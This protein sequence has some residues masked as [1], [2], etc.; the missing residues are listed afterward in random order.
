MKIQ[1]HE[2]HIFDYENL[3]QN[4]YDIKDIA[5]S[6][7]RICRFNGHVNQLSFYSVAEHC[8]WCSEIA[9]EGLRLACLLHDAAECYIGDVMKPYKLFLSDKFGQPYDLIEQYIQIYIYESFGL[10]LSFMD[11]TKISTID[12]VM[13]STEYGQCM[14]IRPNFDWDITFPPT[15]ISLIGFNPEQM[16]TLFLNKFNY[17]YNKNIH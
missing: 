10:D 13:L 14:Y 11:Y 4:I 3:G 15:N 9:P 6:L 7:S 16:T 8:Y 17:L 1:T 12:K 2:G 5:Y